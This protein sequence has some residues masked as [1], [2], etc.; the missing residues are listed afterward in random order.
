MVA[1]AGSRGETT[2]RPWRERGLIGVLMTELLEYWGC[3]SGRGFLYLP[4]GDQPSHIVLASIKALSPP[5]FLTA[6][7][8]LLLLTASFCL[9]SALQL[10]DIADVQQ[11]SE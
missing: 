6:L 3:H 1:T 8:M 7:T 2:G 5:S 9:A 4:Q 10:E 11:G